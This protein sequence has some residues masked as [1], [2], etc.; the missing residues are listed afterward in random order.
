MATKLVFYVTDC[1][2]CFFYSDGRGYCEPFCDHPSLKVQRNRDKMENI[3][4]Y[5]DVPKDCPARDK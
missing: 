2:K 1:S 3:L 4:R 5:S